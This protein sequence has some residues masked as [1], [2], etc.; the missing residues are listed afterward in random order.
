MAKK[1]TIGCSALSGNIFA[2]HL[3]KCGYLW[4]SNKQDVTMDVLVATEEHVQ[5]FG[6]P[7]NLSHIDEA[8]GK[9]ILDYIITV[10]KHE[11]KDNESS[12][13]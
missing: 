9:E 7:V 13:I 10:T 12:S 5:K 11:P 4:G 1:I 8:T 6:E 2:G 3:L